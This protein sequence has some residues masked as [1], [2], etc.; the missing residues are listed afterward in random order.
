MDLRF[1]FSMPCKKWRTGRGA[2]CRAVEFQPVPV[3][4]PRR[5]LAKGN[6]IVGAGGG[7]CMSVSV[8][9]NMARKPPATEIISQNI[10]ATLR[11]LPRWLG[12]RWE[13]NDKGDKWD[14][15][16]IDIKNDRL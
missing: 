9:R 7:A 15:P 10:P 16:P 1:L 11:E 8:K 4:K 2:L 14:K 5:L 3:R 6:G 13:K 12:W